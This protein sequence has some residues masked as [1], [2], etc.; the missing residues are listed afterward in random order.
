MNTN[1]T[2]IRHQGIMNEGTVL[3]YKQAPVITKEDYETRIGNLLEAA[4]SYTHLLIYADKEHF[5]NLE[6]LTGY[7]PRYEECMMLLKRGSLPWMILGNEG[8]GQAQCLTISH[9]K[10]LFQSLSPHMECY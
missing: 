4:S 10:V 9:E 3:S 1:I 5:S 8:M 6:Y 7:D 2:Y